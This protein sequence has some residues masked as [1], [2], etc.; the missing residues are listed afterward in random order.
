[1]RRSRDP[2]AAISR[3]PS[4]WHAAFAVKGRDREW[5]GPGLRG[6]GPAEDEPPRFQTLVADGLTGGMQ[7]LARS[8]KWQPRHPD[9]DGIRRAQ[10]GFSEVV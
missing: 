1:L 3:L 6:Y 5:S 4:A 10:L 8:P 2:G 7:F 9:Y